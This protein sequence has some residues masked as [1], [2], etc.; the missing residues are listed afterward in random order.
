MIVWHMG[1]FSTMLLG[2]IGV[3]GRKEVRPCPARPKRSHEAGLPFFWSPADCDF[4][5]CAGLLG[6][7]SASLFVGASRRCLHAA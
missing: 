1:L 3:Q 6:P 4:R 7:V 5:P 2:Q